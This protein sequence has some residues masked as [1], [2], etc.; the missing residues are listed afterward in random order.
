MQLSFAICK[1][2]CNKKGLAMP[3]DYITRQIQTDESI[4]QIGFFRKD[5]HNVDMKNAIAS[6]EIG[7]DY[8]SIYWDGNELKEDNILKLIDSVLSNFHEI[9]NEDITV[10]FYCKQGKDR[11]CIDRK[12]IKPP[13]LPLTEGVDNFFKSKK[14]IYIKVYTPY[15]SICADLETPEFRH[16][17]QIGMVFPSTVKDKLVDPLWRFFC[18]TSAKTINDSVSSTKFKAAFA[19]FCL[20]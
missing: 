17:P 9:K 10:S 7:P 13:K 5:V 14:I 18:G 19:Q 6:K 16:L 15:F 12:V 1:F 4:Q 20:Q 2:C 8:S 11:N 3:T